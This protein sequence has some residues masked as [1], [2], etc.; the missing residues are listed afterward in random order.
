MGLVMASGAPEGG[1][2]P[3]GLP[4]EGGGEVG[5]RAIGIVAAVGHG[6]AGQPP[7]RAPGRCSPASQV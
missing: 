7:L 1:D 4:P 6:A 2:Q 5:R 3:F